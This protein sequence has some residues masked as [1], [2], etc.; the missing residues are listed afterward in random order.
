MALP[1]INLGPYGKTI[2]AVAGVAVTLLADNVF[3]TN[4][5]IQIVMSILTVLGVYAQPNYTPP[6][7]PLPPSEETKTIWSPKI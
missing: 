3:D 7:A 2:V 1:S 6:N 5:A 4:D